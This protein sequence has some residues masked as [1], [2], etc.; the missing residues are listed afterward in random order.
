MIELSFTSFDDG[1]AALWTGK[2]PRGEIHC[3]IV[4]WSIDP[5]P[6]DAGVPHLLISLFADWLAELGAVI[7]PRESVRILWS[8]RVSWCL[9]R[10]PSEISDLFELSAFPWWQGLQAALI[11]PNADEVDISTWGAREARTILG[12]EWASKTVARDAYPNAVGLRAG[13]DGEAIC[14]A[15]RDRMSIQRARQ[16]LVAQTRGTQVRWVNQL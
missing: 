7:F 6:V 15:T 12:Q 10:D 4:T 8:R 11:V 1:E 14:L 16:A 5:T 13:V 2:I 9:S 3:A